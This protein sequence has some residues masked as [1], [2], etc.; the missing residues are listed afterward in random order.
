M[1]MHLLSELLGLRT[2]ME[3]LNRDLQKAT[4]AVNKSKKAK[5]WERAIHGICFLSA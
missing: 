2:Q 1:Y 5:V 4:K 3:A